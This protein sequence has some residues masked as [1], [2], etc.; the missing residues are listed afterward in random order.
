M[1]NN[2]HKL[3]PRALLAIFLGYKPHKKGFITFNLKTRTLR[4]LELLSSMKVVF[5]TTMNHIPLIIPTLSPTHLCSILTS[6][7]PHLIQILHI[8]LHPVD[9]PPYLLLV[10]VKF[11]MVASVVDEVSNGSWCP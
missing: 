6:V 10:S 8:L 11:S 4:F 1:S 2:R 3:D 9:L 7:C 5:L